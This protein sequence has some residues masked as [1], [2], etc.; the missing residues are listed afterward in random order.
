M[1]EEPVIKLAEPIKLPDYKWFVCPFGTEDV[2]FSLVS[3]PCWWNRIWYRFFFGWVYRPMDEFPFPREREEN[4]D[5]ET[6][7]F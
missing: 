1:T 4:Q 3:R 5:E 2:T 7:P 6:D